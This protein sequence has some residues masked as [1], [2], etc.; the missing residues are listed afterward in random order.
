M[1]RFERKWE[2]KN[3]WD[4]L[5][6][7]RILQS[8]KKAIEI[9]HGV[10]L[11]LIGDCHDRTCRN[12]Y[13]LTEDFLGKKNGA[14]SYKRS[15]Y[16]ANPLA[17]GPKRVIPILDGRLC[18]QELKYRIEGED[19]QGTRVGGQFWKVG[20][21]RERLLKYIDWK[22]EMIR[23]ECPDIFYSVILNYGNLT[24]AFRDIGQKYKIKWTNYD[25]MIEKLL[26]VGLSDYFIGWITGSC[27]S[28]IERRKKDKKT[29]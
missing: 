8:K 4:D 17:K 27:P 29:T 1:K 11:A 13:D 18:W 16:T 9:V 2:G 20:Q 10:K 3:E 14:A 15:C 24:E 25:E 26:A 28:K 6:K 5:E 22:P 23:E 12:T 21:L 19:S 7:N